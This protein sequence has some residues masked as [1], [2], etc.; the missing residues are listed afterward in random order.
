MLLTNAPN[1]TSPSSAPLP[2]TAAAPEERMDPAAPS[3]T[4]GPLRGRALLAQLE[5]L[6]QWELARLA[7][8]D[9]LSLYA[10]A[11]PALLGMAWDLGMSGDALLDA[12]ADPIDPTMPPPYPG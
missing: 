1:A 8:G 2:D 3:R 12:L 10:T 6:A 5:Q 7:A 11:D 9:G 4:S